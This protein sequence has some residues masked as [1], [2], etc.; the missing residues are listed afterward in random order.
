MRKMSKAAIE[1]EGWNNR[2]VQFFY[3]ITLNGGY[4]VRGG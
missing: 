3:A 2:S 1:V 4:G